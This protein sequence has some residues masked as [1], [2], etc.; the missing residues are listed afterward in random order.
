MIKLEVIVI[1]AV[2]VNVQL[3]KN[4]TLTLQ[5]NRLIFS[6]L[7]FTISIFRIVSSFLKGYLKKRISKQVFDFT[8]KTK[9][10][11]S[12]VTYVYLSFIVSYRFLGMG[13]AEWVKSLDN[14]DSDVLKKQFP[15]KSEYLN[16]KLAYPY[17]L[18]KVLM[19]IKNQLLM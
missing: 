12:S 8:H 3:I 19:I 9:D 10:E 16:K 13:L 6:N 14:D 4:V 5:R 1:W 15:D 7:Q 11:Y 2:N 17:E 18:F